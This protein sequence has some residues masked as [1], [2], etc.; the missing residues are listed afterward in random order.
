MSARTVNKTLIHF[1]I[2]LIIM[3][4]G[5]FLPTIAPVTRMGV[6]VVCVFAG[7]I[8]GWCVSSMMWPSLLGI[9]MLGFTEYMANANDSF[10]TFITNSSVLGMITSFVFLGFLARSGLLV[11]IANWTMSRKSFAGKPWRFILAISLVIWFVSAVFHTVVT[12]VL[13]FNLV[14]DLLKGMGYTKQDALPTFMLMDIAIIAAFGT[15]WLP[16]MPNALFVQ[17]LILSSVGANLTAFQYLMCISL[18]SFLAVIVYL[19]V[20]KF[21]IRVDTTKFAE[22]SVSA[23][24]EKINLTPTEKNAIVA[25]VVF[26]LG[27]GLP[28]FLPTTWTP[29]AVLNRMGIVGVSIIV[30]IGLIILNGK[31]G[32]PIASFKDIANEGYGDYSAIVLCGSILLVG[33]SITSQGTGIIEALSQFLIPLISDMSLVVFISVIGIFLALISQVSMNMVL[34]MVFSPILAA[35]LANA[36]YNPLMSIMIAYLAPNL[37]F[38]LPSGSMPAALV[39]SK[40]DWVEKKIL[41]K[42]LIPWIILAL[43]LFIILTLTLPDIFC[44]ELVK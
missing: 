39:F 37:A 30:T 33:A 4:M 34:M 29:I 9:L 3:I 36:G 13:F 38:L 31:D 1:F 42:I 26:V 7:M 14:L 16:F 20:G 2:A 24:E 41:Y 43:I 11:T 25:L 40:T 10:M 27:V 32:K 5:N 8:Y 23:T 22:A 18:P 6:Q 35:I 44:S 15:M 12:I 17:G 28:S 21:I 19:V